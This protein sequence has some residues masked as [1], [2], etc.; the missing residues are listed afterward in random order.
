MRNPS[1][2]QSVPGPQRTLRRLLPG[3]LAVAAILG[4]VLSS[5]ADVV[6]RMRIFKHSPTGA[7]CPFRGQHDL[8]FVATTGEA[9]IIFA[10]SPDPLNPQ[11]TTVLLDDLYVVEDTAFEENFK[12]DSTH[13]C[14]ALGG[15]PSF[16][17]GTA[18]SAAIVFSELFFDVNGWTL[19]N[20]RDEQGQDRSGGPALR[21]GVDPLSPSRAT[22]NVTGL[23]PGTRYFVTGW[24][25]DGDLTV[26]VDTPRPPAFFLQNGRFRLELRHDGTQ[27]AGGE[28]VSDRSAAFWFRDPLKTELIV[29]VV[30]RC[31]D[32]G[33]Y[34]VQVGGT[35]ATQ[36][37]IVI[38]DLRN[39][40][41]VSY[42]NKQGERFQPK[43]DQTTFRCQ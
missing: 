22:V 21:L 12:F 25:N 35:V 36:A 39:G 15:A 19:V 24:S 26:T 10:T 4:P 30:D 38:T 5:E 40:K 41:K 2:V 1:Y 43:I 7:W 14:W 3:L 17:P 28:V 31:Q 29:N 13:S 37:S 23:T 32:R 9:K 18:N 27:L 20:A 16:D 42:K 34:F 11:G 8:W 33:T 6:R